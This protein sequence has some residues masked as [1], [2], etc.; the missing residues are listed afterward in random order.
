M[1]TRNREKVGE[2]GPG[3][4]LIDVGAQGL[5]LTEY[6]SLGQRR[7]SPRIGSPKPLSQP[8]AGCEKRVADAGRSDELKLPGY[9]PTPTFGRLWT[10]QRESTRS[11]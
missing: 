1:K 7:P 2:A 10:N 3:D 9:D 6:Q 5:T 4:T 8:T 11:P